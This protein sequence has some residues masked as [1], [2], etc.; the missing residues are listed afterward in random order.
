MPLHL[1]T[2]TQDTDS[3][4][5][6]WILQTG[7]QE[8]NEVYATPDQKYILTRTPLI[9]NYTNDEIGKIVFTIHLNNEAKA[10]EIL[11]V[12][13]TLNNP[14]K[15]KI[16]FIQRN[17]GSSDS[18]EYYMIET[19]DD[20]QRLE[21]E[22]V[23]RHSLQYDLINR[24]VEASISVF[25]FKVDIYEN[26]EALNR[27][28]GFGEGVTVGNTDLQVAGLSDTF[29]MTGSSSS[30]KEA[31]HYSFMIGT[32]QSVRDVQVS[33]GEKNVDFTIA[34]VKTAL[35]IVPYAMSNSVFDLSQLAK[36]KV[37]SVSA[38]VKA[39]LSTSETFRR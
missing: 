13:I 4:I 31:E 24:S 26:L 33:F 2:I 10:L 28:A 36:G 32:V 5:F 19:Q 15:S 11:D 12:D 29:T 3:K 23:N 14:H 20:A 22:T 35:G 25:P 37:I 34:F 9:D 16:T 21:M 6:A 39:D 17:A 18:N 8:A 1:D 27:W 30:D 38:D 7:S